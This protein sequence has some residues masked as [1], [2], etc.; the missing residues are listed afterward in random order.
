MPPRNGRSSATTDA[1]CEL[2]WKVWTESERL[3]QWFGPK[4][5]KVIYSKNDLRPGGVYHYGMR[6]RDGSEIWGKW[7]Y[8]EVVEPERL[9]FVN[10]FS[11]EKGGLTRH[12][13]S[14]EWPLEMLSTVSFVEHEGKTTLTIRWIPI[15]ATESERKTFDA[16][17]EGM[18]NGWTGTLDQLAVY[19]QEA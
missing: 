16:A 1:P 2:M 9:V 15:N 6:T 12:L 11:D 3:A 8:H 14:P 18:Q 4:G 7:V 13:F 5:V 19:L 10:S 17:H